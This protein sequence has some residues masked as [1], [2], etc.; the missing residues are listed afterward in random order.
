MPRGIFG[1]LDFASSVEA[2]TSQS[3]KILWPSGR[4]EV[5]GMRLLWRKTAGEDIAQTKIQCLHP[6]TCNTDI[7]QGHSDWE[8][9]ESNYSSCP[10]LLFSLGF[11]F[12]PNKCT[13]GLLLLALCSRITC[14]RV[15]RN[16]CG[17]TDDT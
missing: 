7:Y 4:K 3:R 1:Y 6:G 16:L 11:G 17:A 10:A 13:E 8:L 9:F 12:G 2:T 5:K 14:S 15:Q